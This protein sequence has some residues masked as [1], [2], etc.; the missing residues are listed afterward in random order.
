MQAEANELLIF[1]ENE[2]LLTMVA[3][4][5]VAPFRFQLSLFFFFLLHL[6][7]WVEHPPLSIINIYFDTVVN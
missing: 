4:A 6:N 7:L 5:R 2:C 1:I 3:C